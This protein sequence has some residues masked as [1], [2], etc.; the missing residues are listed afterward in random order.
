MNV[1]RLLMSAAVLAATALP[2]SV[3]CAADLDIKR[4]AP[5]NA[6]TLVYAKKNSEREY[7]EKYLA[8]AWK[9]FRDERIAERVFAVS[10]THL[11]L[12]TIYSV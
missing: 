12:P 3:S 4:I 5:T 6:H 2:C 1:R 8:D 11:T 7:Q 10:Y 9:T